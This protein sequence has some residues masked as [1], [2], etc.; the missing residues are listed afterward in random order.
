[1]TMSRSVP[2]EGDLHQKCLASCRLFQPGGVGHVAEMRGRGCCN[3]EFEFEVEETHL[4]VVE[5]N[6]LPVYTESSAGKLGS[7]LSF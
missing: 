2:S 7:A 4:L 6:I 5:D 3:C 1:M